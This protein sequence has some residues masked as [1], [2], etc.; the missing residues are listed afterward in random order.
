MQKHSI[1][2]VVDTMFSFSFT[3]IIPTKQYF[4]GLQKIN[5]DAGD[6]WKKVLNYKAKITAKF[7]FDFSVLPFSHHIYSEFF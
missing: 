4:S 5:R 2:M 6:D 3:K 7:W 1:L